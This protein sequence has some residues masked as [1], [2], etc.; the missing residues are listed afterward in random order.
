VPPSKQP[1]VVYATPPPL[2]KGWRMDLTNE[3][4]TERDQSLSRSQP[5]GH[6]CTRAHKG[7][8]GLTRA[9]APARDGMHVR[10]HECRWQQHARTRLG[11]L[12]G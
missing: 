4:S 9:C 11:L 1:D 8:H 12:E 7:T 3:L 5:R 2:V 6:I 10:T